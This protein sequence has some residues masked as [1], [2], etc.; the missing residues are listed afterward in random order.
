MLLNAKRGQTPYTPAITILL[1]INARLNQIKMMV[2]L[3]LKLS[4]LQI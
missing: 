1:Q 2:E 4:E 3:K